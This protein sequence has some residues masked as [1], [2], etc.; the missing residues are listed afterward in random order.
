MDAKY[1]GARI[2]ER[3][4]ARGLTQKEL[5]ER[6]HI[7]GGAVSKWERGINFPDLSLMESLAAALDTSVIQLLGLEDAEKNEVASEV[8]EISMAEKKKLVRELKGR[9]LL[10]I[11]IGLMLMAALLTA[12]KILADNQIYGLAQGCTTGMLGFAGT[13]IGTEIYY[14]RNLP[15]L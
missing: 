15:R 10:N 14:L 8:L 13:M 7:T 9:A 12:S 3:R 1:V 11:L 6:L 5:A 4:K 2:A